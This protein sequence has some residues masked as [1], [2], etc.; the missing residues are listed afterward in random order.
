MQ[1]DVLKLSSCLAVWYETVASLA[2]YSRSRSLSLLFPSLVL[3]EFLIFA[4][5]VALRAFPPPHV[6]LF[7]RGHPMSAFPLCTTENSLVHRYI[8]CN[9]HVHCVAVHS[10]I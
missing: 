8:V 6:Y 1:F 2:E 7:S 5:A 9:K 4:E 3:K 10:T